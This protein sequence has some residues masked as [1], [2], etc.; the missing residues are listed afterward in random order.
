M[1]NRL[2]MTGLLISLLAG[3]IACNQ[4][5]GK[6]TTAPPVKVMRGDLVITVSGS[7][8]IE[9]TREADL[10][11][12]T[13][14]R[15]AELLVKEG[16]EVAEGDVLA[17]LEADALA[18]ALAQAEVAY[19]QAQ[20]SANQ[21]ALAVTQAQVA[22][23][24]AEIALKSAEIAL[25]QTTKTST[26]SDVRIAQAEVDTAKR[27]L[28]DSLLTLSKYTP[29]TIGYD[30]YQKTV[31]LAQ[32][33][34]KTAQDRLDAMLSGSGTEEMA[35]KQQQVTAAQQA[36]A[37]SRQSLELARLS[38]ELG[39]QSVEAA[40]QSRDYAQKQLDK[41]VLTA[42]FAGVIASVP[43]DEG[44]TVLATTPIAVLIEPGKMEL[45][46]QVD[47]IDI[48][49]VKAGQRAIVKVDALP[50]K[51]LSGKVIS[52]GLLP[53][54]EAGVTLFEVKIAL[55]AVED[56]G[57]RGGMSASADIV[58][59]ER[60]SALLVPSRAIRQNTQGNTV[61]DVTANG[62]TVE[63]SVTAG[64]SD[65]LQTEIISGLA[66]GETVIEKRAQ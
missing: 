48:P 47:E 14:G 35:V 64:I 57:L 39:R 26:L 42:P 54:K 30:E 29:G 7:G 45:R 52:I 50:E 4:P 8:S 62:E 28:D 33:R 32:A 18:L 16:D 11:F 51:V 40:A 58:T 15:I 43:V 34:M 27:N 6:E 22:V 61:V 38:A 24:Q 65:G 21:S 56:I 13:A 19:A 2:I 12:G 3:A 31:V 66:E 9:I 53:R 63:K 60:K 55:D 41:A 49:G 20:L 10:S 5:G 46:V 44:D 36:L 1:K 59:V 23:T 37:A 25:E 17:R